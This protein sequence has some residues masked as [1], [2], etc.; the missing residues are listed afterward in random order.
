MKH[1]GHHCTLQSTFVNNLAILLGNKSILPY[2]FRDNG[3]RLLTNESLRAE[4]SL[5]SQGRI[6]EIY[7]SGQLL[8]SPISLAI[9]FT[10]VAN[11]LALS[12]KF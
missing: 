10:P 7:I 9:L 8:I 12:S 6:W 4:L 3:P 1:M 5:T 2:Y 11:F